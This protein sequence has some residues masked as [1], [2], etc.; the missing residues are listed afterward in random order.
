MQMRICRP[1]SSL[2]ST[3]KAWKGKRIE[4]A[5][6]V[7]PPKSVQSKRS[8]KQ[9]LSRCSRKFHPPVA[10]VISSI[11]LPIS[12][13]MNNLTNKGCKENLS[14]LIAWYKRHLTNFLPLMPD[15]HPTSLH[16]HPNKQQLP[17]Q[18]SPSINRISLLKRRATSAPQRLLHQMVD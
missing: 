9:A 1:L 15:M 3:Q 7:A 18:S 5:V 16:L 12:R 13:I 8:R 2:S 11:P 14:H 17:T 4:A 6:K 10:A